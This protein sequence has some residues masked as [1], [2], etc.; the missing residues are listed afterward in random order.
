MTHGL[1]STLNLIDPFDTQKESIIL[2]VN[3]FLHF[4]HRIL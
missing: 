3:I 1:S 2:L 4:H